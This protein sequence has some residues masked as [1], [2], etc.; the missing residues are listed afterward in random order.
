M[1]IARLLASVDV[2]WP[3]ASRRPVNFFGRLGGHGCISPPIRHH[4]HFTP[5]SP[6]ENDTSNF[7][8]QSTGFP[9]Q[10]DSAVMKSFLSAVSAPIR[11]A[12]PRPSTTSTITSR[13]TCA[14][15]RT[16]Q[17]S[18][19]R[20]YW[21]TNGRGFSSKARTSGRTLPRRAGVLLLASGGGAATAGVLAFTDDIKY[22]YDAAERAGRVAAALAVCIND[23]RTT[24]NQREKE[25]DAKRKA[26]MLSECHQRCANRT[27]KV[28][29]KNGGIFI[30]LGQHL[31]RARLPHTGM[32]NKILS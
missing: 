31:V 32:S 11:R 19:P 18:R 7:D 13:W 2:G 16:I 10:L 21:G 17:L 24:L 14:E 6:Q 23:Y 5:Q 22:G 4:H 26:E 25:E 15:C 1:P 12:V 9:R 20:V 27:L 30:K 8:T 3:K 29:E 28:L